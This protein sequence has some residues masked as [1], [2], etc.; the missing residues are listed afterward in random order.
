M[1]RKEFIKRSLCVFPGVILATSTRFP[2]GFERWET[3]RE[4]VLK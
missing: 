3:H 2:S 4:L 1:T